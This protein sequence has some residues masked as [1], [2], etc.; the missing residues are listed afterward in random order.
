VNESIREEGFLVVQESAPLA[1]GTF[2][3]SI[4]QAESA[5]KA[6]LDNDYPVLVIPTTRFKKTEIDNGST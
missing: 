6:L 5:A 4:A 2:H 3:P 1:T